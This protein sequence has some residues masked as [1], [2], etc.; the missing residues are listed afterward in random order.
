MAYIV[1]SLNRIKKRLFLIRL[2]L[3]LQLVVIICW[4]SL[5]HCAWRH[6]REH[7]AHDTWLCLFLFWAR[8]TVRAADEGKTGSM[9]GF[10]CQQVIPL[11][12]PTYHSFNLFWLNSFP[13]C[14]ALLSVQFSCCWGVC[15]LVSLQLWYFIS[16]FYLADDK[17][18][19]VLLFF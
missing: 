17:I 5:S 11:V 3:F 14:W 19:S 2:I 1:V 18:L 9:F 15:L 10:R 7:K 4:C 16:Y 8:N 12:P 13:A 6:V